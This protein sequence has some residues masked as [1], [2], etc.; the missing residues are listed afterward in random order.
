MEG[1]DALNDW[2][3]FYLNIYFIQA[4]EITPNPPLSIVYH[5]PNTYNI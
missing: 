4:F 2:D 5:F 3:K 1:Y